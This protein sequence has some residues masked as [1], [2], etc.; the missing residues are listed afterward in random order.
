MISTEQT[1]EIGKK[2]TEIE[3]VPIYNPAIEEV[4]ESIN[5]TP[6]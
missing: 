6:N 2:I 1:Q 3:N 5:K 4:M